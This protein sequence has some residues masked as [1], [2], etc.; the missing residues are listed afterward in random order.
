MSD[1][2]NRLSDYIDTLNEERK[3][4]EHEEVCE[5]Q[6]LEKLYDT[7]RS[8]KSLKEPALPGEDFPRRLSESV[9]REFG[10]NKRTKH[11]KKSWLRGMT[12]AVAAMLLMALTLIIFRLLTIKTMRMLWK[13][14]LKESRHIMA[15]LR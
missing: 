11:K 12:A 4:K 1:Y 15:Y 6:E 5:D 10:K 8:V 14:P 13:R 3:P 9:A 7:V 2:E